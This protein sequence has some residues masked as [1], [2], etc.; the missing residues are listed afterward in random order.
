MLSLPTN[1]AYVLMTAMA[2]LMAAGV[3]RFV[4]ARRAQTSEAKARLGSIIVWWVLVGL[5]LLAV[6]A[7]S[8]GATALTALA[9]WLALREYLGLTNSRFQ[10]GGSRYLAYAIGALHFGLFVAGGWRIACLTTPLLTVVA[11]SVWMT[12]SGRTSGY[13]EVVGSLL[14]AVM[15]TVVGLSHA[16]FLWTLPEAANPDCGGAGWFIYLLLLTQLNDIAQALWGRAL[17][18]HRVTPRISPG[19]TWE[20]LLLGVATTVVL[21]VLLAPVLTPLAEPLNREQFGPLAIPYLPAAAAGLV[22]GLGGFAGD[23]NISA[24][25]RDLGVKD[26]GNLLPTQGGVL[27]RLDS[28]TFAAPLFFYYVN[29]LYGH[30]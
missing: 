4:D 14:W 20:G 6:S 22:I 19:K 9:S 1:A 30:I 17:G 11:G 25:K 12:A 28:L 16:A 29:A 3:I 18:R 23:L 5:M 26:S 2:V 7:G 24:M 10:Y 21:A 8:S 15:L 13:L 27:D